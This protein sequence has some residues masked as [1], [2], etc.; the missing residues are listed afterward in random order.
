MLLIYTLERVS[1]RDDTWTTKGNVA[2]NLTM[3]GSI[4]GKGVR[5]PMFSSAGILCP[6]KCTAY[7][8]LTPTR[9]GS[10]KIETDTGLLSMASN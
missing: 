1:D 6:A 4:L 9:R 3:A 5:S 10:K 8:S 7:S 2:E